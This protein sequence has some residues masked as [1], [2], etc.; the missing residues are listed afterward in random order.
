MKTQTKTAP[1]PTARKTAKPEQAKSERKATRKPASKS[2]TPRLDAMTAP[3]VDIEISAGTLRGAFKAI[4]PAIAKK[5]TLPVLSHTL[6]SAHPEN[7]VRVLATNMDLALWRYVEA[8]VKRTGVVCFP[9]S[10]NEIA[11]NLASDQVMRLA[12]KAEDKKDGTEISLKAGPISTTLRTLPADEFPVVIPSSDDNVVVVTLMLTAGELA[13]IEARVSPFTADDDSRPIL[14]G[15][16]LTGKLT[17]KT[18]TLQCAAADGFRLAQLTLRDVPVKV[19]GKLKLDALNAI[20]PPRLFAEA[21]KLVPA[22]DDEERASKKSKVDEPRIAVEFHLYHQPPAQ[23]KPA[24]KKGDDK[25]KGKS[26]DKP[27]LIQDGGV[28]QVQ[29]RAGGVMI[30]MIVGSFPDAN[31]ILKEPADMKELPLP[32]APMQDALALARLFGESTRLECKVSDRQV[33]VQAQHVEI[34]E[35]RQA[36][37]VTWNKAQ[38]AD[39]FTIAF[40]AKFLGEMLAAIGQETPDK[41]VTLRVTTP[42]SPGFASTRNYHHA[43]MP[44]SGSDGKS[45]V[46]SKPV[47]TATPST[48]TPTPPTKPDETPPTTPP[49]KPDEKPEPVDPPAT[50]K[51]SSPQAGELPLSVRLFNKQPGHNKF[52]DMALKREGPGWIVM[53]TYGA[54]GGNATPWPIVQNPAPYPKAYEAYVKKL[55]EQIEKKSYTTNADGVTR[56]TWQAALGETTAVPAIQLEPEKE[57]STW[58]PVLLRDAAEAQLGSL[59]ASPDWVAQEKMD[60]IRL[61]LV[62][63]GQTVRGINR[64]GYY[65]PIPESLVELGRKL[66]QSCQ[67][68]GELIGETYYVF[69]VLKI[70]EVDLRRRPYSERWAQAQ[71]LVAGTGMIF[72]PVA[73]TPEGKQ[74]LLNRLQ[75]ARAEGVV[76]KLKS[77][78][79]IPGRSAQYL[80]WKFVKELDAV[81]S[82]LN[83]KKSASLKLRDGETWREVGNVTCAGKAPEVG[84]VVTVRYLNC[85]RGGSL[86]QPRIVGVR[87]DKSDQDCTYDQIVFKQGEDDEN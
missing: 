33:I 77:A 14:T 84:Q 45:K 59:I 80:R 39:E 18:A 36:V 15:I 9:P 29:T 57:L 31:V 66:P 63:D 51:T 78:S 26:A 64:T 27:G 56:V 70:G 82:G 2:A 74:A 4:N 19:K 28:V 62:V 35:F 69:D 24:E 7:L 30:R 20:V 41:P 23:T 12:V 37:P 1:K 13:D 10:M 81:V 55:K 11:A 58:N 50:D 76:F 48:P 8:K 53:A 32:Y 67:L 72:V 83:D 3:D 43:L 52:Y 46:V 87:T 61:S 68:D 40:R 75:V 73:E 34:G 49:T 71:Q 85:K 6:I 44:M 5:S 86:Y 25:T 22:L 54:I 21:L 17:D 79:Y 65:R 60:G 42:N 16:H 38:P 47:S